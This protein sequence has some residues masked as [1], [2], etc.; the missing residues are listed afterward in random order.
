ML[1]VHW[2][3]AHV[4]RMLHRWAISIALAVGVLEVL[5]LHYLLARKWMG[6]R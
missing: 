1:I 5:V 6:K 4:F 3:L 2:A